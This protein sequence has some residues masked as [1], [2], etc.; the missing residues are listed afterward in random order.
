MG[1]SGQLMQI[2]GRCKSVQV[3]ELHPADLAMVW[4]EVRQRIPGMRGEQP[5]AQTVLELARICGFHASNYNVPEGLMSSWPL[6]RIVSCE[7]EAELVGSEPLGFELDEG[8]LAFRGA[9]FCL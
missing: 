2:F 7:P 4:P 8:P 3:Q 1:V 9:A 5:A 6:L